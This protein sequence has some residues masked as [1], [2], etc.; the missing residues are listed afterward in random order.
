MAPVRLISL[1][2]QFVEKID[3]EK[4]NWKD[5]GLINLPHVMGYYFGAKTDKMSIA[6]TYEDENTMIVTLQIPKSDYK[7]KSFQNLLKCPELPVQDEYYYRDWAVHMV[8]AGDNEKTVLFSHGRIT[9]DIKDNAK[10][11]YVIVEVV[12]K[13][14]E[15]MLRGVVFGLELEETYK[16]AREKIENPVGLN[17]VVPVVAASSGVVLTGI[18]N[19]KEITEDESQD[20][21]ENGREFAIGGDTEK[22]NYAAFSMGSDLY[23]TKFNDPYNLKARYDKACSIIENK[24]INPAVY[25]CRRFKYFREEL[26]EMNDPYMQYM[27]KI[28]NN[29]KESQNPSV[30]F[31]QDAI[32]NCDVVYIA[33]HGSNDG[34]WICDITLDSGYPTLKESMGELEFKY[35]QRNYYFTYNSFPKPM[36]LK[37]LIL[38]GCSQLNINWPSH[39]DYPIYV[40]KFKDAKGWAKA[41]IKNNSLHGILGYIGPAPTS[42]HQNIVLDLFFNYLMDPMLNIIDAWRY[43]NEAH[44]DLK[45][46]KVVS[47]NWAIVY[48]AAYRFEKMYSIQRKQESANEICFEAKGWSGKN[49]INDLP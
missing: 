11:D 48:N 8:M 32:R 6:K 22:L 41:L 21:E 19:A 24:P 49:N 25:F 12:V 14:K 2:K 17:V 31:L 30:A 40:D 29:T 37:W 5:K 35:T 36:R 4:I 15:D 10:A 13:Q 27:L 23:D 1:E 46:G 44:A 9:L 7:N 16:E 39:K 38:A 26:N 45:Y 42:Y 33:T 34:L 47:K 28:N 3:W 43:A 18:K 20:L